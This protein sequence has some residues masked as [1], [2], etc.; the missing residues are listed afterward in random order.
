MPQ[1]KWVLH[2]QTTHICTMLWSWK[3]LCTMTEHRQRL[4]FWKILGHL[5][6]HFCKALGTDAKCDIGNKGESYNCEWYVSKLAVQVQINHSQWFLWSWQGKG[7][8]RELN[9]ATS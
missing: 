7:A 8:P 1:L 9:T 4:G 5:G 2:M 6:A 3:L